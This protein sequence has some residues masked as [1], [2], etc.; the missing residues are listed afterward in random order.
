MNLSTKTKTLFVA[1]G[2]IL[3][4]IGCDNK[5]EEGLSNLDFQFNFT[6]D[7]QAF[8]YGTDFD[9]NGVTVNIETAQFY[10]SGI[11][12][13]PEV[14]DEI[15]VDGKYL[16]VGPEAG[17]L[18]VIR[19]LKADHYHMA[20]FSVGVQPADNNQSETDFTTRSADDPLAAHN[21]SMH[22]NWSSGY[23]FLRIDGLVDTDND[24]T[25]ETPLAFHLG[26]DDLLTPLT[27]ALHHDFE[28]GDNTLTFEFDLAKFFTGVDLSIQTDTHTFNDLPL[29][30]KVAGN[31]ATA[32]SVKQ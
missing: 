1:A 12:L 19:D 25:P 30:E 3:A 23:K 29:A 17:S 22:W 5:T 20:K 9:I 16:L 7:G 28:P 2:L 26:T 32:I 4:S 21:P 15:A 13:E 31:L 27:Y 18:E 24:G 6:V 8:A 11:S 10:L 14:G